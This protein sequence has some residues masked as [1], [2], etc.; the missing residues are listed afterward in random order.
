M[1]RFPSPEKTQRPKDFCTLEQASYV[2]QEVLRTTPVVRRGPRL[3]SVVDAIEYVSN[4]LYDLK[5]EL[6]R[7]WYVRL[8]RCVTRRGT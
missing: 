7:P 1:A 2:A 4:Q 5:R 6:E 8:W 3:L